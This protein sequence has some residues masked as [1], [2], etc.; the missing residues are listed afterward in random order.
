MN[1][2]YRLTG[3]EM[4][5]EVKLLAIDVL[6]CLMLLQGAQCL[7][8]VLEA[9][10]IRMRAAAAEWE[11]ILTS[12]SEIFLSWLDSHRED[13]DN[14]FLSDLGQ[15]WVAYANM[16]N[17]ATSDRV[18]DFRKRRRDF[19]KTVNSKIMKRADTISKYEATS[20]RLVHHGPRVI[21]N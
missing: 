13:L 12:D 6:R 15:Y 14:F 10:D 20:S 21:G 19:L 1:Q 16:Q 5:Y 11:S 17:K 18:H 8:L 4:Q 3:K 9:K 2:L 7:R